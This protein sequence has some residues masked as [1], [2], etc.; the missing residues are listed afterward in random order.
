MT[1]ARS[2]SYPP[3]S[4]SFL[5]RAHL[6]TR[7]SLGLLI[8][9][10]LLMI[11]SPSFGQEMEVYDP[12]AVR[13]D[14]QLFL[15]AL[16]AGH[17]SVYLHDSPSEL[18]LFFHC[19]VDTL[20][21]PVSSVDAYVLAMRLAA[22]L[23]DGHTRAF[24]SGEARGFIGRQ[25][26]LPF[27]VIV[28]DERIF[29]RRD[30][31][32]AHLGDGSEII[33]VDGVPSN[34]I[35]RRLGE[36]LGVDG[37]STSGLSYRL[38]SSYNSFYRTFPLVFGFRSQY[39]LVV[40]DRRTNEIW[41][42]TVRPIGGAEFDRLDEE[43]YGS[44]LHTRSIDDELETP[45]LHLEVDPTSNRAILRIRRF[46]REDFYE[47]EN[48]FPDLY[49]AAF[50]SIANAG[51]RNLIIDLRGNGGGIGGNVAHLLR[52]LSDTTFVPTQE[53]SFRGNDLYYETITADSLG[54]D[55]YF[56]LRPVADR[57]VASNQQDLVELRMFEPVTEHAFRGR[58]VVLIDGG[59][60]S[61]AGMAAGLLREYTKAEFVGQET[62]GYSGMSNGIRQLTVRGTHT[63]TAINFPL[64]HSEF[65]VNEHL[66][67]RGVVPDHSV[68]DSIDDII[69]GRDAVLAFAKAL[70][71]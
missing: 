9:L 28:R 53:I 63:D 49:R 37:G 16:V 71:H 3:V 41:E 15:D 48:T 26:L 38:G 60:V 31:S 1:D 23:R 62:G 67:T 65:S 40:R 20:D 27:H 58:L 52:Y 10:A 39:D 61:A 11:P 50:E 56:D 2:P 14:L 64:A 17:P 4:A 36:Y 7:W 29:V 69:N 35:V 42:V 57:F 6:S 8:A 55:D 54:L 47:P 44:R 5:E 45:P 70:L 12:S 25:G 66:R 22:R 30:L 43:R 24:A 21:S 13:A 59:T 68:I 33:L 34:V 51:V 46:F 19:L 18:G 32:Q